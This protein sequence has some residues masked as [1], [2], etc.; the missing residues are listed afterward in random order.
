MYC[1]ICCV[2]SGSISNLIS[3]DLISEI[4][5][6]VSAPSTAL[7]EYLPGIISLSG[8]THVTLFFSYEHFVK[9]YTLE[10]LL[11]SRTALLTEP[12]DI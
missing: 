1:V 12:V 11:L 10:S 8:L 2:P 9:L 3:D 5:V 7:S 4:I 6:N